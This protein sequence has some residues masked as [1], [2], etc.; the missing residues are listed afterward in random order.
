MNETISHSR[1]LPPTGLL[2]AVLLA[3]GLH[4]TMPT[5]QIVPG[6]WRLLGVLPVILGI[7]I[8][9][10]AEKQFHQAETTVNP[11]KESDCLVTEGLYRFSRNPMYLGM[12]LILLGIACLLGSLTPFAVIFI[13]MGW[14]QVQFIR[15]EEQMLST[16]FGQDWLEYTERV[17]RWF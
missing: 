13:F 10:A 4:F 9:Y 8:S 2:I 1:I 14:I 12:A 11:F 5:T 6:A 15:H 3:L 7:L 17:R 16:Q